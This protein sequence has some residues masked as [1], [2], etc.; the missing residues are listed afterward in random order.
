MVA[1][2][3]WKLRLLPMFTERSV[4][5]EAAAYREVQR[6]REGYQAGTS[7]VS[8]VVVLVDERTGAGWQTF[9]HVRFADEEK[10]RAR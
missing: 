8:S 3:K 4:G 1:R 5:S 9:E 2:K 6:L 7:R 10:S